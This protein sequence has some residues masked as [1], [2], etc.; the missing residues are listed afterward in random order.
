M[1]VVIKSKLTYFLFSFFFGHSPFLEL[2]KTGW[3][4]LLPGCWFYLKSFFFFVKNLS[5]DTIPRHCRKHIHIDMYHS[6]CFVNAPCVCLCDYRQPLPPDS[7]HKFNKVKTARRE[8]PATASGISKKEE[9]EQK[10]E[11]S[12]AGCDRGWER[13]NVNGPECQPALKR[14]GCWYVAIFTVTGLPQHPLFHWQF[15]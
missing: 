11:E 7:S 15:R 1:S 2:R 6:S 3:I 9:G 5:A 10:K 14:H 13:Q 8:I 12:T 4:R